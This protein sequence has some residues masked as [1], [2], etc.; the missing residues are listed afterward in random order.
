MGISAMGKVAN[1]KQ[2]TK[3]AIAI[4]DT[5]WKKFYSKKSWKESET[6]LLPDPLYRP[7]IEDNPIPSAEALLVEASQ[8]VDAERWKTKIKQVFENSTE[9]M[10]DNPFSYAYLLS[11]SIP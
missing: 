4:I 3:I 10:E 1:N 2:A 5:A 11:I 7:H 6:S 8:F 9:E